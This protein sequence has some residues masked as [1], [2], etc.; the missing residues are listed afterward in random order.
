MLAAQNL[1][2][3]GKIDLVQ[4]GQIDHFTQSGMTM[5]DGKKIEAD[6]IIL[7]TGYKP[8]EVL[9]KKIFGDDVATRVGPIWGFGEGLRTS[10]YVLPNGTARPVVYCWQLCPMPDQLK[11]PGLAN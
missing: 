11:V 1:L 4:F 6:I 2:I 8:Q 5:S 10:K 7:A 3:D 9:V